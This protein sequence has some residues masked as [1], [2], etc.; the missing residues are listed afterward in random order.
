MA[1]TVLLT[2]VSGYIGL[3]CAYR[4]L[5][6]GYI[7]RGSV[8]NKERA[9]SAKKTIEAKNINK[10]NFSI[11]ELDLNSD[12]GW[13]NATKGCSYVMHVASPFAI[14]NPK[15][16]DEVIYPAV[17]GTLR[18]LRAA[19]AAKVKRF[20]LTSSILSMMGSMKKGVVHPS[21]WTDVNAKDV[22]TYTKSKT[23][24]E[25]AA[26]KFIQDQTNNNKMEL[27]VIN[28]GAVFGP[29]LGK[30]ISGTSMRVVK[31]ML[32]GRMPLV[33]KSSFSMVDVRDVA[34]IHVNSLINPDAAGQRLI[35][36]DSVS[37]SFVNIAEILKNEGHKRVSTWVAPNF[38]LR[39]V[40]LLD[41]DAKGILGF[42]EINV[43]SDNSKTREMFNWTPIPFEETI[44]ETG[45]AI[46][47]LQK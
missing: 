40:A 10:N 34:D 17:E 29:P 44:R 21:D 11:V 4:L 32:N 15:N 39:L 31:Q 16:E 12:E 26:W 23:L 7:V 5:E 14:A 28:P 33:P 24:A 8:R 3:H 1:E 27:V 25:K 36:A 38:I 2:G 35:V 45:L 19:Q 30:D 13:E 9:E 18:A 37:R 20:V 42:L 43:S 46:E 41:R 47:N 6:A 22:N